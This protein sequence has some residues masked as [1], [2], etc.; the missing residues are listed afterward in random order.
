M[1]IKYEEIVRSFYSKVLEGGDFDYMEES[2]A[3]GFKE[4]EE[5]PPGFPEGI[6]G[7]KAVITELR[8][9]FPDLKVNVEDIFTSGDKVTVRAN[10]QGTHSG[11]FMNVPA[12]GKK[13]KVSVIDILRFEGDKAVEH[14][15]ITDNMALMSQIG[16]IPE[17]GQ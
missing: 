2:M 5:F 6:E 17:P 9:G 8:T 1:S 16:A 15:G 3:P 12:T 14:W 4:H 11:S 7:V 10:L 13:I